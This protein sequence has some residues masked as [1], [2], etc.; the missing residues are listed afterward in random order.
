ME[1]E[2]RLGGA[3]PRMHLASRLDLVTLR[4]FVA[5]VEEA[6]ILKAAEREHIAASA[7]SKRI[8][9]LEHAARTQLLQR[10]RKGVQPTEAGQAM[11]NHARIILRAVGQLESDIVDFSGGVRGVVRLAVSESAL[12]GYFPDALSSF[13][14]KYPDIG[15][16]LSA[17]TSQATVA[18]VLDGSADI[19]IFWADVATADLR[20]IPCY[21]DRLVVVAN[22]KHPLAF[23]SEVHFSQV[24]DHEIIEQE[25]ESAIQ[26]LLIKQA[27]AHGR[28]LRMHVRVASYDA[29]CRMVQ[30]GLGLGIV[31]SSY[32]ARL[33]PA[34][35]VREI[36]LAEPWVDRFYKICV[37]PTA[38]LSVAGKLLLDQLILARSGCPA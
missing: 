6:S 12:F 29:V 20:V 10:H 15:I 16:D 27:A 37:R 5:V 1:N 7:V 11:L 22:A 34:L 36:P 28:V 33:S 17:E 18:A 13:A 32:A 4:L 25:P 19:G 2:Q 31:P 24:L 38:D 23:C 3:K 9:D 21:S 14:Q 8:A 30:A 26:A 35:N